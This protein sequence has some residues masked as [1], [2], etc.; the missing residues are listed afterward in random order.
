MIT[1]EHAVIVGGGARGARQFSVREAVLAFTAARQE[2]RGDLLSHGQVCDVLTDF[3]HDTRS[4]MA[5]QHG[6]GPYPI[7]IDHG[8][9]RMAQ[10]CSPNTNQYLV[11]AG[12]VQVQLRDVQWLRLRVGTLQADLFEDCS[13]DLHGDSWLSAGLRG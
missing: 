6:R 11:R 3:F 9:I 10:A 12:I 4:L 5:K 13:G 2:H 7:S 8:K 1:D